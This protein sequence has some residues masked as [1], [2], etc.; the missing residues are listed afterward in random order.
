MSKQHKNLNDTLPTPLGYS[1]A[2]ELNG[3]LDSVG[4]PEGESVFDSTLEAEAVLESFELD[5]AN[6]HEGAA[7]HV[8]AIVPVRTVRSTY[9]PPAVPAD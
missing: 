3:R 2:V 9:T 4:G 8:V 1:L 6:W 5:P 7:L